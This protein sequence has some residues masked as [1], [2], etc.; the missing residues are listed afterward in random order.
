MGLTDSQCKNTKPKE[1]PYRL[2]DTGGLYLQVMPNGSK[3]WRLKYRY[4][5]K[6]KLLALG[7]YPLV[8]LMEARQERD[9]AK[10]LLAKSQ[11]PSYE[12]KRDHRN[13]LHSSS[14]TF[15]AV[16]LEWRETKK[17][18]WST[19]HYRNVLQ[20]LESDL[21]PIIGNEPIYKIE[22]P[23]LLIALRK[24]E[25][26]DALEMVARCRQICSMVFRYG[27]LT[28]KCKYNPAIDL[29]GALRTRRKKHF[30]AINSH[31]IPELLKAIELNDA[32]LFARTRR[33]IQLSM[34]T[35][36]RPGELRMARWSEINICKKEWLIP[37]ERMKARR[38]H[39]VPLSIQAIS[40]LEKQK[41]ETGHIKTDYVFPGRSDP[42]EPMSDGTVRIALQRLGF[43]DRM[44]A[45]GFRAL[46][47]T[48]IREELDY[49]PDVIEAQLAHKPPGALGAT[50][51]RSQFLK[52]RHQMMQ[53]WADYL[54]KCSV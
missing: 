26:R 32:R 6:E 31:E 18:Q 33:A 2:S 11:D 3:Y 19:G 45:H 27:V 8:S 47:R 51:D 35:F 29:Q 34:L 12:K 15:K 28:G 17:D 36:V 5:K 1:K 52:K 43:K 9:H 7:T 39:F 48:A 4:L 30:A 40:I 13:A 16:A 22:A 14:N 49:D 21:F 54:E 24:I 50:Y 41:D 23:D 20:R 46:A 38:P 10:K 44:T 37:A 53:N 42:Q 25:K